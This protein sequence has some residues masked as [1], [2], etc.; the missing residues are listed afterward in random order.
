MTSVAGQSG[1]ATVLSGDVDDG[2]AQ[3]TAP[4]A[5]QFFGSTVSAG[6]A[7]FV[8]SNGLLSLQDDAAFG[9][10]AIPDSA[11][12]NGYIAAFWDDIELVGGTSF[13][14]SQVQGSSPN[15]SWTIEFNNLRDHQT[16][17]GNYTGQIVIFEQSS[18]I[19]IRYDAGIVFDDA[20]A[21][22]GVENL[23][24]TVG[25]PVAG[26]PNIS[27][28]P[29]TN[30]RFSPPVPASSIPGDF[31]GN[32][33]VNADD[34]RSFLRTKN[35]ASGGPSM[36]QADLNGDGSVNAMDQALMTQAALGRPVAFRIN[37]AG[38]ASGA[39]VRIIGLR[40]ESAGTSMIQF[41]GTNAA[42]VTP[43]MDPNYPTVS[44]GVDVQVPALAGDGP[45]TIMIGA[46]T[47][48]IPVFRTDVT[49][50]LSV[51]SSVTEGG[52]VMATVTLDKAA[53]DEIR[54][55][56]STSNGSAMSGSDF[57]A[58]TSQ[59]ISIP[60]GMLTGSVMISTT[61]DNAIEV[62]ENFT[63]SITNARRIISGMPSTNF[64][65]IGTGSQMPQITDN[66]GTVTLN[67]SS[68]TSMASESDATA[69]A[70]ITMTLP[71]GKTLGADFT[72]NVTGNG[73]TAT[74]GM[75]FV[76]FTTLSANFTSG[77]GDGTMRS[78]MVNLNE[79]DL[80]ELS[81]TIG[82]SLSSAMP[83]SIVTIGSN[84]SHT[85]SITDNDGVAQLDF[86]NM[87]SSVSED[88]SPMHTVMV[89][90]VSAL[91]GKTLGATVTA[92]VMETTGSTATSGTDFTA[93]GTL[94]AQFNAGAVDNATTT[95]TIQ[96]SDDSL[97]EGSEVINLTI[98]NGAP[99]TIATVTGQTTHA[100]T[101]MDD[102]IATLAFNPISQ[103]I[104]EDDTGVNTS[105][106]VNIQLTITSNDAS[107]TLANAVSVLVAVDS[108]AATTATNPDDY[109]FTGGTIMFN[110][111][112]GSGTMSLS[113]MV[114]GD[115]AV[116]VDE[117]VNFLLLNITGNATGQ[118]GATSHLLTIQDD[119]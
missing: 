32:G 34:L 108:G 53:L 70:T 73:G 66:D 38:G 8:S 72:A 54:V 12:P 106:S 81:E 14:Y 59:V 74:A 95:V 36:M 113:G 18:I 91:G 45:V 112:S 13:I 24:G 7:L 52:T 1:T 89:S 96:I 107:P 27:A 16:G 103:T 67:F 84:N 60:A 61:D 23:A 33:L 35:G 85:I 119:D 93:I 58:V 44:I 90:Y 69:A 63:V 64:V 42:A 2:T 25:F 46:Q 116:E 20:S 68:S 22:I 105:F 51:T 3:V 78:V 39:T 65:M 21:T 19:D 4:F 29:T 6:T 79:D 86:T 57:T 114:I 98:G 11:S 71:V 100:V 109:T 17:G 43:V 110:A 97:V 94:T 115:V 77:D 117:T 55:D 41:N 56:L 99:A 118:Q 37:P 15:R 101:I 31:V 75:D 47:L 82:L 62:T 76:S 83:M 40:L 92:D 80:I 9:N 104:L 30:F 50:N 26:S 87:S 111:G 88:N 49:A 28:A 102:D 5:F 48:T 10:D